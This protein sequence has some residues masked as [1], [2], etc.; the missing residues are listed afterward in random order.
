MTVLSILQLGD[1]LLLFVSSS[2]KGEEGRKAT[3][4]GLPLGDKDRVAALAVVVG[5]SLAV[6]L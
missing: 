1:Q 2:K 5:V 6:T 3:W 4:C